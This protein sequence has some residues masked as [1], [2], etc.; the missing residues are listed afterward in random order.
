ME[1]CSFSPAVSDDHSYSG[2]PINDIQESVLLSHQNTADGASVRPNGISQNIAS[3]SVNSS[4]SDTEEISVSRKND[5]TI[6]NGSNNM[7]H[8]NAQSNPGSDSSPTNKDCSGT[9]CKNIPAL[10]MINVVEKLPDGPISAASHSLKPILPK[11][12]VT[13][14]PIGQNRVPSER[15]RN[16]DTLVHMTSCDAQTETSDF[17]GNVV[18]AGIQ[19]ALSY[20]T[21]RNKNLQMVTGETQTSGDLI[22]R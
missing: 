5:S 1:A 8:Q 22:L 16:N 13:I 10:V 18:S 6:S 7:S 2:A 11:P 3:P 9:T 20:Q 14:Y 4:N 17:H 12:V 19:T 15:A 21:K